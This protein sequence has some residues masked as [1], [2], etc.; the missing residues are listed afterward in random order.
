[1]ELLEGVVGQDDGVGL[2]GDLQDEG[3]AA[4]DRTGRRTDQLAG[5]HGL[6]VGVALGG[7]DAVAEGGVDHHREVVGRVFGEEGPDGFVE[8][9][10]ARE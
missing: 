5:Q 7:I 3:V 10:Q 6:F 8:L 9:L 1:M 4:P 2:V